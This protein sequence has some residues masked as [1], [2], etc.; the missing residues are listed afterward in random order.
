MKQKTQ[1][2][3]QIALLAQ[4]GGVGKTTIATGLAE[5]CDAQKL[6]CRLLDGNRGQ[7]S[8]TRW[9]ALRKDAQV[10][11]AMSVTPTFE[12][13]HEGRQRTPRLRDLTIELLQ[14]PFPGLTLLDLPG[15]I[16]ASVGAALRYCDAVILPLPPMCFDYLSLTEIGELVRAARQV[17]E[18]D[19]AGPIRVYVV[20]NRRG[21]SSAQEAIKDQLLVESQKLG[22]TV[23]STELSYLSDFYASTMEG[24]SPISF[25]PSGKAAQQLSALA[26]EVGLGR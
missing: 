10:E 25:A 3:R 12:V 20:L 7:Q 16:E 1:V 11:P 2:T 21:R 17:R 4:K 13:I 23:C 14:T 8:L 6:P 19:G 9:A 5:W 24:R 15:G 26:K 18:Q 22:F